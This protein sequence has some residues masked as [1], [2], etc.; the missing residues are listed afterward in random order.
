[1]LL[2]KQYS[3]LNKPN[4]NV[5][6]RKLSKSALRKRRPRGK[7]SLRKRKLPGRNLS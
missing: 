5:L 2:K 3:K 7:D 4:R 1:M 6:R